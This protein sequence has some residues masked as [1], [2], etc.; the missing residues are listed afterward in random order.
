MC[1]PFIEEK[2]LLEAEATIPDGQLS[3]AEKA[4]NTLGKE[5]LFEYDEKVLEVSGGQGCNGCV[6][7]MT[8]TCL[9]VWSQ[10]HPA[11][12]SAFA[13][14]SRT[15][16]RATEWKLPD[17]PGSLFMHCNCAIAP[18]VGLNECDFRSQ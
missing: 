7:P 11:P 18:G 6:T 10:N 3:K 1:I 15:T 14:I 17:M 5:W 8:P 13:P 4:R 16:C 9:L 2:R 12:S